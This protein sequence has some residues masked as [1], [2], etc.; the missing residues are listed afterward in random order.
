MNPW[1]LSQ[2]R[3]R[4]AMMARA[5]LVHGRL[6]DVGCGAKPYRDLFAVERY[7]GVDVEGATV[8][9]RA[10]A[11]ALPFGDAAFDCVLTN[12]VLEHVP[13]PS[14]MMSEIARVLK[15]GG[16]L[17]LSAPMTWGLHHEPWDFYRYTPYGLRHLAES[18]GLV[19]ESIEATSGFFVTFAQRFSDSLFE[20]WGAKPKGPIARRV[21]RVVCAAT[22]IQGAV[23]EKIFGK[24][25]D[26]LDHVMVA[27]RP[28]RKA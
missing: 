20:T 4:E 16:V 17:V 11:L 18:N 2:R 10:S 8:D 14:R 1:F 24:R 13:E 23:L 15:P 26:A 22:M 21:L 3:L 9:A 5:P 6:L 25:G 12:E 27:R 28:A 7:V 19:V